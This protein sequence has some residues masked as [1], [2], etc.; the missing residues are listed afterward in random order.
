M[1]ET[2][3]DLIVEVA[4]RVL[5]WPVDRQRRLY[6]DPRDGVS[7]LLPDLPAISLLVRDKMERLG[8][9]LT[10]TARFERDFNAS[11][12]TDADEA[13]AVCK[14]ALKAAGSDCPCSQQNPTPPT[15]EAL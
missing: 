4:I 7:K 12:A 11:E 5:S 3:F 13:R 8:F 1:S 9:R 6:T 15:S 10:F 14:A 2:D